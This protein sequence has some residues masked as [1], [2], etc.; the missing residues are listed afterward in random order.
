MAKI[1]IIIPIYNVEN[2]LK[3]CV[4]SVLTQTLKD[5]EVILVNDGST[6]SSGEMCDN[7]ANED[8]RIKVIHKKNG[9]LSSARNEGLKYATSDLVGF[10]D[11]DDWISSDM[12]EYLWNLQEKNDADI[13]SCNYMLAFDYPT[14]IKNAKIKEYVFT[15]NEALKKYLELGAFSRINDYSA[16]KKIYKKELFSDVEFP[17]GMLF[18]DMPTNFRLIQ[19]CSKYVYSTKIC[20]FYFQNSVSITRNQYSK[21]HND[22][23]KSSEMIGLYAKKEDNDI[24]KLAKILRIKSYFSLLTK[25]VRFGVNDDVN[26]V[27]ISENLL[28]PFRNEYKTFMN[29]KFSW[30]I[31]I[32]GTLYNFAWKFTKKIFQLIRFIKGKI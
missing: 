31:K 27:Y 32:L 12:Y 15:R 28:I 20:Y 11:S 9:G 13:V 5:I 21:R 30:K 14:K 25:V 7:F 1:S 24:Q 22:L 2:Y 4:L 10:I 6:D 3:R 23:I 17:D 19:K 26:D 16:W 29:S 8:K 18:E